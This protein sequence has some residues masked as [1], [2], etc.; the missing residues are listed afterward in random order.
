MTTHLTDD[1]LVLH[2]Y[3]EMENTE[4]A[5]AGAH[6]G[7][8]ITCQEKYARLQRVMA[9]AAGAAGAPIALAVWLHADARTARVG[10]RPAG[11]SGRIVHRRAAVAAPDTRGICSRRADTGGDDRLGASA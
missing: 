10:R 6:L 1:E 3:G 4:E 2:Y 7:D 9:F 8:C 5:R 11:R